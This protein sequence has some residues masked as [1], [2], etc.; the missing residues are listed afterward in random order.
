MQTSIRAIK[1]FVVYNNAV[2]TITK[3]S[4]EIGSNVNKKLTEHLRQNY[5][6]DDNNGFGE[7]TIYPN[8]GSQIDNKFAIS[9]YDDILEFTNSTIVKKKKEDD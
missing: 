4:L 9:V 3:V 6:I 1:Y 8:D 5:K 7:I 2:D